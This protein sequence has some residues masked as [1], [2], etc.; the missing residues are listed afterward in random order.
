MCA[1]KRDVVCM[2]VGR[3]RVFDYDGSVTVT[4][5]PRP[6]LNHAYLG[7][8]LAGAMQ[9]GVGLYGFVECEMQYV[10]ERAIFGPGGFEL[11]RGRVGMS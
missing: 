6:E 3:T 9:A 5:E 8:W 11:G 7:L 1:D 10:D 2:Q 4:I